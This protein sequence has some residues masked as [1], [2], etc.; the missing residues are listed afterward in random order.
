MA[1]GH[2]KQKSVKRFYTGQSLFEVVVAVAI[3]A[4]ILVALASLAATS[5]SNSNFSNNNALAT[6]YAQE[7]IEWLREQRD[8]DWSN[9][10]TSGTECLG[11]SPITSFGGCGT[12]PDTVFTRTVQFS[13]EGDTTKVVTVIVAWDDSQGHHEVKSTTKFTNWNR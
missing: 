6:K 7:A 4:L 10:P 8:E 12:I 3:A 13:A 5:V 2:R 11:T 1:F 9:I